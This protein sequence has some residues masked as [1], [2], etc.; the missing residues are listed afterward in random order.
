MREPSLRWC[1][2]AMNLLNRKAKNAYWD[3]RKK[4]GSRNSVRVG[5]SNCVGISLH[6]KAHDAA[7]VGK[8]KMY[9]FL[10]KRGIKLNEEIAMRDFRP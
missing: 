3:K 6:L 8:L 9:A 5:N 1:T 2:Q 4:S 10:K 7:K